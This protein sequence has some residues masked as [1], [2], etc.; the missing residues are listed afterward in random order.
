MAENSLFAIL[1][2]SPW[3]VSML[4]AGSITAVV[5]LLA[6]SEF[7]YLGAFGA[8]PLYGVGCVAAEVRMGC[9]RILAIGAVMGLRATDSAEGWFNRVRLERGAGARYATDEP[10]RRRVA[11]DGFGL[12]PGRI[13]ALGDA[14]YF[15]GD[16]PAS[17]MPDLPAAR[18][19]DAWLRLR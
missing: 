3:W 5:A 11:Y 7:K 4:L 16:Q 15:R 9:G 14:G 1:L 10:E 18:F 2:R 12:S 6:P 13:A 8:L 19:V 17:G